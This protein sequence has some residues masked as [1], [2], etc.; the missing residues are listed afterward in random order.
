MSEIER[1]EEVV[2]T[3]SENDAD[4]V[5]IVVGVLIT[6]AKARVLSESAIVFPA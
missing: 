3:L 5:V 1:G 6:V 4:S 2:T